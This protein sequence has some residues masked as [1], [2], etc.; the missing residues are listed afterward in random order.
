MFIDSGKCAYVQGRAYL[1]ESE[2]V[3]IIKAKSI[4]LTDCFTGPVFSI[5]EYDIMAY[6]LSGS[7]GNGRENQSTESTCNKVIKESFSKS[8]IGK[9]LHPGA[10]YMTGDL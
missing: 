5:M 4:N 7:P 10:M 8:K 2:I 3:L 9:M 6:F 1:D